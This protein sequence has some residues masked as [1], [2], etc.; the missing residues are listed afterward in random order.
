M[1]SA[2]LILVVTLSI[3][4]APIPELRVG[5]NV[6]KDATLRRANS[7]NVYVLAGGKLTL[8]NSSELP[9]PHRSQFESA[10][11]PETGTKIAKAATTDK[12]ADYFSKL[13][14]NQKIRVINGKVYDF[15]AFYSMTPGQVAETQKDIYLRSNPDHMR[16]LFPNQPPSDKPPVRLVKGMVSK[17]EPDGVFV[18]TAAGTIFAKNHIA[19]KGSPVALWGLGIGHQSTANIAEQKFDTVDCGEIYSEAKHRAQSV[20]RLIANGT[21]EVKRQN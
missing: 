11:T 19:A 7:T 20:T 17:V 14:G 5:T 12:L 9:E 4:S 6:F 18:A 3:N 8:V 13:D 21:A 16:R 15:S 2:L 10:A 1:K